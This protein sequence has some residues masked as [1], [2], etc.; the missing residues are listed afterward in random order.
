LACG[1]PVQIA[2]PLQFGHLVGDARHAFQ[3]DRRSD[4]NHGRRIAARSHTI[5]NNLKY[6]ALTPGEDMIRI[7][8]VRH[9]RDHDRNTA[10]AFTSI[11][12]LSALET[13]LQYVPQPIPKIMA[14]CPRR[15]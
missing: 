9:F 8:L 2:L 6:L 13:P 7:W 10:R 3:P 1:H 5:P 11:S 14:K 4:L 15:R 12:S